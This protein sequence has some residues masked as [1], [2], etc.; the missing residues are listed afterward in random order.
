MIEKINR[1]NL[2]K[3]AKVSLDGR[4]AV[5][6]LSI[7]M[8]YS[9]NIQTTCQQVQTKVKTAIQNMTGLNVTDVNVRRKYG[10]LKTCCNNRGE[11]SL[12]HG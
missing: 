8:G 6:D 4:E 7:M 3:G 1:G 12:K 5:V 10:E 11:I 9:Y 2:G